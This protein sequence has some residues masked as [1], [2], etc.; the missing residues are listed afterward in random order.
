MSGSGDNSGPVG[1]NSGS[2]SWESGF[3]GS[4]ARDSNAWFLT[5]GP[6]SG[7]NSGSGDKKSE[8]KST[9]GSGDNSGSGSSNSGGDSGSVD[10]NSSSGSF[11]ESRRQLILQTKMI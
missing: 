3:W 1:D 7:D 10:D 5:P 9:S 8:K 2:G 4:D 6:N 11:A